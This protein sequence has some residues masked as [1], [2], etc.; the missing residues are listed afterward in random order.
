VSEVYLVGVDIS[1]KDEPTL[2]VSVSN[3]KVLECVNIIRG[4]KALDLYKE[5]V[6]ETKNS[7]MK[8]RK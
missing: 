2:A 7:N 3:G 4:Q 8:G 1:E 5:L 6:P